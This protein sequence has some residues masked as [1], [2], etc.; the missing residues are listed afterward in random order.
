MRQIIIESRN[1]ELVQDREREARINNFIIHGIDE[2]PTNDSEAVSND[3]T[4]INSLFQAIDI[5]SNPKSF[6]RIGKQND[7]KSRPIK[8]IMKTTLDKDEVMENLNKL[9]NAPE[10]LRNISVTDDYTKE[11]R[12]I[13]RS[14]V[15]EA[16]KKTQE[17]GDG[18]YIWKVRGSPKNGL[19]LMRF[20]I[21]KPSQ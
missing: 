20:M 6:F 15:D 18:K 8:V 1:E 7:Q 17:E 21:K 16:N 5:E 10:K 11:E 19:R 12:Q 13:I 3:C 4:M 9:K 2:S 14:K